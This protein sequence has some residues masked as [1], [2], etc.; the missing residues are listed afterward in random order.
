[1]ALTARNMTHHDETLPKPE[2]RAQR[3]WVLSAAAMALIATAGLILGPGFG[4]LPLYAVGPALAAGRG[5]PRTVL[6]AATAATL[7]VLFSAL[8]DGLLGHT[9]VWVALGGIAFVTVAACWVSATRL[10]AE[11]RLVD[12]S[13]VAETVQNVLMPPL[14]PQVGPV[15]LTGS[16]QSATRAARVGGDLY[17]AVEVLGGVRLLIADVQGK[18]LEAVNAA[19]VV[20][21]AFRDAA[22]DAPA[23]DCLARHIE[24]A[25]TERTANDRFVTALFAE[26]RED[27]TAVFLDH[28]H[29]A[30]LLLRANGQSESVPFADPAP[31]LGLASLTGTCPTAQ[32]GITLGDGDRLLFCTD[33]L[34]EARDEGGAF[35]PLGDHGPALLADPSPDAALGRLRADVRR[36]TRNEPDDDSALL[37]CQFGGG[38]S[39]VGEHG[40]ARAARH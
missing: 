11:Q 8:V 17:Q 6:G 32:T 40:G 1:M 38:L 31:P 25:L 14:P 9:R 28:G 20:L 34:T 13:A 27:G 23:L 15:G 36:H 16:Y 12:V 21:G 30:P 7:L 24:E 2:P 35:Y 5:R 4:L 26:I 10:R 18:G 33:G 19:A 22:R 39:A 3:P 29:P 37:L